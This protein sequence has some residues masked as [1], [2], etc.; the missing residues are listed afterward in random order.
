MSNKQEHFAHVLKHG[1]SRSNRFQI[2][3]P[4][5]QAL[6]GK[7]AN[8]EQSKTSTSMFGDVIKLISSFNG[9]S[10]EVTRGLDLMIEST[11]LPGKNLNTSDIRY[12]GDFYKI[13]YSVVY[14]AQQ[15]T[16]RVSRDLH[17]KNLIDEW[18]NKIYNP[19]THE[20]AYMDDYCTNITINQLDE[21]DRIVYSVLL[22]DAFP[23]M[24]N[25]LNLSN[26]ESNQFHRLA[27]MFAYRRWER[28]GEG[29]NM[30]QTGLLGSLS[31]TVLGPI[32]TPIL[33]NPVVKEALSTFEGYT[34]INL[35]GEAVGIYNQ[36]NQVLLQTTGT[37]INDTAGLIG[38]IRAGIAVNGKLNNTQKAELIQIATGV[39]GALNKG[40]G[41]NN[42]E[43]LSLP[44]EGND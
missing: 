29:E 21:Q 27:T 15:F 44:N 17:E 14:P 41:L 1:L 34:G 39:L 40:V 8:I 13:P 26:E 35:E 2:L 6:L 42:N 3:I 10:T 37:S 28:V 9:T 31:Q 16:F 20:V 36:I 30:G 12:N 33:S 11:E 32:V 19:I 7:S 43:M 5:P 22:R 23:M 4:L 38:Q 18:M 24:C 25:P